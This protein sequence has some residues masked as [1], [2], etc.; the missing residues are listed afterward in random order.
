MTQTTTAEVGAN[1]RDARIAK[2]LSLRKLGGSSGVDY[3]QISRIEHGKVRPY[4]STLHALAD[5]L[6]VS[7]ASLLQERAA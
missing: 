3:G 7:V 2:G 1:L 5:A 6:G 4:L